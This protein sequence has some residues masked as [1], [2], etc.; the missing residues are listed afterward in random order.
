M[1]IGGQAALVRL[2]RMRLILVI[3]GLGVPVLGIGGR[4]FTQLKDFAGGWLSG[5]HLVFP[6]PSLIDN[7][8]RDSLQKS[9][10]LNRWRWN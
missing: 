10:A 1:R 3:N 9:T 4:G 7:L 6:V 8:A 2:S 5:L